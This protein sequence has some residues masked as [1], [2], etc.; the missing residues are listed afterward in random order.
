MFEHGVVSQGLKK[1]SYVG[2]AF[3]LHTK[4]VTTSIEN[5]YYFYIVQIFVAREVFRARCYLSFSPISLF[6][7]LYATCELFRT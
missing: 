1:L 5:L 6:D 3:I 7:P 2:F 4:H